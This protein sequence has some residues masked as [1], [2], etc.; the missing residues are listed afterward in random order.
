LK[1]ISQ[2]VALSVPIGREKVLNRN[3]LDI[4]ESVDFQDQIIEIKVGNQEWDFIAIFNINSPIVTVEAPT[5]DFLLKEEGGFLIKEELGLIILEG[6]SFASHDF[7]FV[8][9]FLRSAFLRL[10]TPIFAN[11][12]IKLSGLSAVSHHIGY[13]VVGKLL[14]LA[15]V[16]AI[17][18]EENTADEVVESLAN[19]SSQLEA[20]WWREF[21]VS[22]IPLKKSRLPELENVLRNRPYSS[23]VWFFDEECL[24]PT[25][26]LGR[27]DAKRITYQTFGTFN[28]QNIRSFSAQFKI[29]ETFGDV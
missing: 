24:P 12:I 28:D 1:I 26:L 21:N 13:I 14:Q 9:S 27:L 10:D 15:S 5:T 20:F 2:S 4:W 17:T 29:K 19:L 22:T 18:P 25:I 11:P 23:R 6:R 8:D 7:I 16:R 3:A